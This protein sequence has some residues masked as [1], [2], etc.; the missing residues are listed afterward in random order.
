M[1]KTEYRLTKDRAIAGRMRKAGE[2]VLL[3]AAEFAAEARWGGLET[4][5][6]K[7]APA[8]ATVTRG[9]RKS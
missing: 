3:T 1:T 8:A 2:T 9:R 4:V 7:A 5:D 6:G